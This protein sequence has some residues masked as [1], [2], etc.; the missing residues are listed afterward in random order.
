MHTTRMDVTST[1]TTRPH[2][3]R[4]RLTP[5][6]RFGELVAL[7]MMLLLVDFFVYHQSANTG[8]FTDAFGPQAMFFL[9]GPLALSMAAPVTRAL[10]GRRNP[11]RP[12]EVVSNLFLAIAGAWLLAEFPFNFAHLADALPSGTRFL[13]AWVDNDVGRVFLVLQVIV[14]PIVA[15]VT[16]WQY[17]SH[18]RR[19]PSDTSTLRSAF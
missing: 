6:Q 12:L 3:D 16:A 7:F 15:F 10:V 9:Y 2:T 1:N 19:A 11:A 4:E 5:A 8:F 17:F 14:C 18:H 13:L